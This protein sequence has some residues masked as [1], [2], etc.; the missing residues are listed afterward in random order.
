VLLGACVAGAAAWALQLAWIADDAYISFRY[1]R[2]WGSGL[3]PV[4]NA[5]E[6]VEGYTNFL[7][8]AL[9]TPL[10]M[11]GLPVPLVSIGLTLVCQAAAL[12]LVARLVRRSWG[13]EPAPMLPIAVL[14]LGLNYVFAS[15]GTSGL[16]TMLGALLV[17]IAIE[18]ASAGRPL[19]AGL[20]GILATMTHPDHSLFYVAL[21]L[22]QLWGAARFRNLVRFGIPFAALYVPYFLWRWSYYGDFFPNTYYAKNAS[23]WYF[24]QGGRYLVIS[25]ISTGLWLALPLAVYAIWR[26]RRH[27]IAR[28]VLF[29]A[30]LFLLYVAK[31]GG[32][33]MLG[34]LLCP[35][36]PP[37]FVLAE[38]GL[39]DLA[40]RPGWVPRGLAV[41]GLA[42]LCT[43][44]VPNPI[45]NSREKY[46]HLADERTYYPVTSFFPLEIGYGQSRRARE[47]DD[48]FGR[49]ERAPVLSLGA[50]GIMGYQTSVRIARRSA[51]GA[52]ISPWWSTS[53]AA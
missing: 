14:L 13:Q 49:L 20:A 53:T 29:A 10:E 25:G 52:N 7:W 36:L 5:G 2:N 28:Y 32:D 47:L 35:L 31:I 43:T 8:V 41:F 33:F 26:N 39:R 27:L 45:I 42:G 24:V 19:L 34:R 3:G 48:A 1:A 18:R 46:L 51:S 44:I 21:A 17:L 38:L 37:V 4:Y 15:Y 50:I 16:E 11:L 12:L 40:R 6:R 23:Q 30:P 9:L 22:A